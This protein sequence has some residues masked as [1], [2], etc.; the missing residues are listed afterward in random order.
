MGIFTSCRVTIVTCT[1]AEQSSSMS[2][3]HPPNGAGLLNAPSAYIMK[4][5]MSDE[6]RE[7]GWSTPEAVEHTAQDA[8]AGESINNN[9]AY[10]RQALGPAR[11]RRS[12]SGRGPIGK[13]ASS[14][15]R[16]ARNSLHNTL[17]ATSFKATKRDTY[18]DQHKQYLK[19]ALENGVAVKSNNHA[20]RRTHQPR[21]QHHDHE[22]VELR[23]DEKS[24]P[25]CAMG[26]PL[27]KHPPQ[28]LGPSDSEPLQ[29]DFS[30]SLKDAFSHCNTDEN[31]PAA[32]T[33]PLEQLSTVR[34]TGGPTGNDTLT[35]TNSCKHCGYA[36][37]A[38]ANL[39]SLSASAAWVVADTQGTTCNHYDCHVRLLKDAGVWIPD[40]AFL[41][42]ILANGGLFGYT[43]Q[44]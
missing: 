3:P 23:I 9:F 4:A 24:C 5:D 16:Q 44:Q 39:A 12:Q 32:R 27:R 21:I 19:I 7:M 13:S 2:R 41:M 40:C 30:T 34:L 1:K 10:V 8:S 43:I 36:L 15:S 17:A 38:F 33:L 42:A 14:T 25:L 22:S 18:Q 26:I 29:H 6:F 35:T 20:Y 31:E 37:D 28:E 11:K